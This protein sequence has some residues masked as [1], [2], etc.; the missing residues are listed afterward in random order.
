MQNAASLHDMCQIIVKEVQ[1]LTGFDRVMIY[2]FNIEDTGKVVAEEK[3]ETLTPYFGLHYPDSD[4]PEQAKKLFTLNR[5]RLIP[6]INSQPIDLIPADNPV[7]NK[8]L[9]LSYSVLRSVS[10]CHLEYLKNMGVTASMS[11]S[12]IKDKKLW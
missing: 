5:L 8:P 11:I 10:P 6:D 2:Q 9:D 7:T 4:I 1:K 12:L 3:L